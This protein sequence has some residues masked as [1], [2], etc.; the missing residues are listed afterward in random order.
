[1]NNVSLVGRLT[2]DP[3]LRALPNDGKSV[4]D[5]RIAVND[6]REDRDPLYIDVATFGKQA[7]ACAEYLAK[8]RQV[9]VSG[10][11]IYREW[12][13]EDDSPRSKHSVI[14]RVEFLSGSK[15]ENGAEPVAVGAGDE[16]P[17]EQP[18]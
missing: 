9:A 5:M 2:T 6:G 12:K 4:C 10:K 13:A 15:T 1:M 11:L 8:G 16:D 18:F 3:E 17:D 7:E 14:G